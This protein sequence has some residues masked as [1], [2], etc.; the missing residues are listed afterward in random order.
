LKLPCC[1]FTVAERKQSKAV[2]SFEEWNWK[3]VVQWLCNFA[4]LWTMF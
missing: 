2:I 4:A 3:K 1:I